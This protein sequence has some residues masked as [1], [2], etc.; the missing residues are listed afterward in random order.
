MRDN[1]KFLKELAKQ[2]YLLEKQ[3]MGATEFADET[4]DDMDEPW[5]ALTKDELKEYEKFWSEL[6]NDK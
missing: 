3:G 5:Y 2:L 4:R 1:L 6:H